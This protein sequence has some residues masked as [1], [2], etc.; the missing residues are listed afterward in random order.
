MNKKKE[1]TQGKTPR[2]PKTLE[3]KLADLDAHLFLLREHRSGLRESVAHL[4]DISAELRA[5]I[6]FS[7][8]REGLL[9]RLADELI[10]LRFQDGTNPRPVGQLPG[11]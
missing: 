8:N 5:L 4:K 2:I 7:S 10:P 1:H 11:C 3:Q 6:C 9:W